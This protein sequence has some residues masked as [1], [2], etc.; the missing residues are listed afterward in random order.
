MIPASRPKASRQTVEVAALQAWKAAGHKAEDFPTK[1]VFASRAYY[2][3]SMGKPDQNDVGIYDDAL[4]ILTPDHFSA[5]NA[6]TDPSR[7]GW[8]S[9]AGKY[10]AR[11]KP[12]VWSFRRLKHKINSPSGYMAFGQGSQPVTVE[13]IRQ[14]GT[15]ATT[16]SGIY[17]I[18]LHRGGNTGTS[19]EGCQTIPPAQWPEFDKTLAN[20]IGEGRFAYIL[21]DG[22]IT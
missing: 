1:Y 8:N 3:D 14:D 19:S 17:G 6:N 20:I 15:I 7:Y 12:G 13:R 10:M 21:A 16:E 4:F 5:W 18:N 11:L 2:E 22:P 9:G